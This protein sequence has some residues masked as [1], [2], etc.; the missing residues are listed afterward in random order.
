MVADLEVNMVGVEAVMHG[1]N[2]LQEA[3]ATPPQLNRF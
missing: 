3:S 2:I 1:A